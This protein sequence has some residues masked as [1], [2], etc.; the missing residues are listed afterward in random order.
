[1]A[2][3]PSRWTIKTQEAF[4]GALEAARGASHPEV[5]PEHLLVSLLGQTDGVV[6]PLLQKV[7]IDPR[8]LRTKAEEALARQPRAYG[9]E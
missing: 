9:A 8:A 4:N 1:M 6:V 5:I 2:F 3:D 7:G